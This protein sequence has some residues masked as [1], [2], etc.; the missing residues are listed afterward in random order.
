MS[1]LRVQIQ[2]EKIGKVIKK[3]GK[4]YLELNDRGIKKIKDD[5]HVIDFV[6]AEKFKI[7]YNNTHA[8]KYVP[9]KKEIEDKKHTFIGNGVSSQFLNYVLSEREDTRE[10]EGEVEEV[11]DDL[12]F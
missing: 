11:K 9:N 4:I 2:L 5:F 1:D 7:D 6:V 3:D 8:V 12:P 10:P